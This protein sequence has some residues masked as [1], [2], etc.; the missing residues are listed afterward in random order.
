M[1]TEK[2]KLRIS[3]A[4]EILE[5][6][7]TYYYP[8]DVHSSHKDKIKPDSYYDTIEDQYKKLCEELNKTPTASN[9]V[10]FSFD[11]PCCRLIHKKLTTPKSEVNKLC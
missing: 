4:W 8:S 6:K 9:M 5:L 1:T 2:E 10:G 3:L 7:F 11:R